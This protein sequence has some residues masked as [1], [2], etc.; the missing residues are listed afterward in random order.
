[1]NEL[2]LSPQS[3]AKLGNLALNNKEEQE[4]PLLKAL[5]EDDED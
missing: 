3:R 1:C 2:S 5:R 4:D